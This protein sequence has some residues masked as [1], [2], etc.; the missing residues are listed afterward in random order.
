MKKYKKEATLAYSIGVFPT[1]E[2]LKF[3][4]NQVVRVLISER[5]NK[6]SGIQQILTLCQN[7]KIPVD[8]SDASIRKIAGVDNAYAIGVFNKYESHLELG[9]HVVLV[10]PSDMGNVGTIIRTI[11]AFSINNLAIIRPA[12]DVFDPKAV[13]ASMGALFKINFEYFN[14]FEEYQDKFKTNI[15]PFMLQ[16]QSQ[17]SEVSFKSPF[18]LVF[19]NEGEGLNNSYLKI[20]TSVRIPQSS[21]VDSLNLSIALGIGIYTTSLQNN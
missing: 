6:N 16:G 14:S 18:A 7:N 17:L 12:V 8:Y 2:L 1:L 21:D 4:L 11:L 20:G 5:G 13:R 10:N 3:R 9:N 15:Y 19:G